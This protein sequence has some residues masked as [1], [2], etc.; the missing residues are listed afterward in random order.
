MRC[1]LLYFVFA[2]VL[3]NQLDISFFWGGEA[4]SL[5]N[6]EFTNS[7]TLTDQVSCRHPVHV[8]VLAI[9]PP[10]Y[11]APVLRLQ[12]FTSVLGLYMA[13]GDPNSGSHT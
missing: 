8:P 13:F 2:S 3:N 10:T 7:T 6:L 4:S 9:M 11:T 5:L 1:C 12:M